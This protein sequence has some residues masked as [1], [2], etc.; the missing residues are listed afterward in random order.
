MRGLSN[1]LSSLLNFGLSVPRS[2]GP[3]DGLSPPLFAPP[4]RLL[5]P[6]FGASF[7]LY[8]FD[9]LGL[10]N[11][12]SLGKF[13]RSPLLG[14]GPFS[15]PP[16]FGLSLLS[17]ANLGLPLRSP[18][19][20]PSLGFLNDPLGLPPNGAR[21]LSGKL[22]GAVPNFGLS[23]PLLSMP[24]LGL[25]PLSPNLL[26]PPNLG[27]SFPRSEPPNFGRSV[28]RSLAPNDGLSAPNLGLSL[29][30]PPLLSPPNL[31]LSP[32]SPPLLSPPNL[33]LSPLSPPLLSA[34]Y[35]GLSILL[36][37]DEKRGLSFTSPPL[38][39]NLGLSTPEAPGLESV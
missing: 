11:P 3:N 6:N 30:S 26:S 22:L 14:A 34:P 17:P 1:C 39:S 21:F 27:R 29:L 15:D 8:P 9:G 4:N 24:N 13:G 33:G 10:S 36:S 7:P 25:S 32:L 23:P 31:G 19:V 2:L 37:P 12:P 18:P 38:D 16:N 35:L 5:S 20:N 28:P